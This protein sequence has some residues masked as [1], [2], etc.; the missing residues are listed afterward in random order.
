MILRE[1]LRFHVRDG[2]SRET[3][4]ESHR[5][6]LE[7]DHIIAVIARVLL[8]ILPGEERSVPHPGFQEV[9]AAVAIKEADDEQWMFHVGQESKDTVVRLRH[10]AG[11]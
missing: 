2:E 6:P 11:I 4:R 7:S 8:Q 1:P 3:G 10:I 5:K 9:I